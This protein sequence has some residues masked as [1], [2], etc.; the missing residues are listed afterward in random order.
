MAEREYFLGRGMARSADGYSPRIV[1]VELDELLADLSA[2]SL[3]GPRGV[4][5]TTTALQ[6]AEA[7]FRL[8]DPAALEA[9][10]ADPQRLGRAS[11][12]VVIDEWQRFPASWDVVRRAVDANPSPGRFLLTGSA[13]PSIRPTHSGAGRIVG[14]RMRP[15]ALAERWWNPVFLAP[16][17]S[18]SSLLTGSR[19][20]IDGH[21]EAGLGDY[22][23]AIT[24]GGFP[25]MPRG[26]RRGTRAALRGYVDRIVQV[27]FADAGHSVRNPG[28]LK[29]WMTAYAAASA[30]TASYEAIR[31]A[32][33]SGQGDKPSRQATAP[34]SNTLE[35]LW[36]LD[37]VQAWMP[38]RNRLAKLTVGPKHH[39]A[40]PA[41]AATLLGIDADALLEGQ[42]AGPPIA[43]D[44]SLLG[45]L[46]ESLVA[47]N[48]RVYAQASE[49][50][51]CHFRKQGNTRE[52]DFIVTR[53]DDRVVA[54][55]AKLSQT[56]NSKDVRHLRW[57]RSEIGDDLL[58]AVIITT[59]QYAYR[60][61]DGIAVVPAALL[62]P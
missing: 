22:V 28:A 31:D 9:L 4:G 37:P 41:L 44:G 8:D 45:H 40:D 35:Q 42:T 43:R 51:V 12:L 24:A 59:G 2:I 27:D 7:I 1:D 53:T 58:D 11:G 23:E 34:Y 32:A 33:T 38:T 39:L 14:V 29:R 46:F 21:T 26:S 10:A 15:M 55:E 19:P 3:D 49:A 57:L 17:V 36:V 52:I 47:L 56:V 54:V 30:T 16:T 5:K 60:R 48:L 61:P 6:R 50:S 13:S 25:G 18:L 62:G 20:K